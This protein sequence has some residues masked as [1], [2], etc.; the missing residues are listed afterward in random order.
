MLLA[1]HNDVI[2]VDIVAEKI[3]MLKNKQ[4]LIVDA[5]IED[6]LANKALNFTA[7]LDKQEAYQY[8][9]F[10]IIATPNDYDPEMNYFNTKLV[11][12]VIQDVLA[13]NPNAVIV[14]KSTVPVDYTKSVNEKFNISNV[15]FLP[16]FLREGK[17]LHH[18]LYP[19]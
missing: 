1:Q 12:S 3:A 9:D 16:E 19:Y 13:I 7:T 18:N 6:F 8:A 2:A 4:S 17:A 5:E 14:I 15:F 11:E 10:V